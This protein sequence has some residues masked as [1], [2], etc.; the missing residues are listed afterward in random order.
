MKKLLAML[1]ALTML[2]GMT[3]TFASAEEVVTLKWVTVGSGMPTNYDAW[4]A[5]I[6][7]YLA[8]KIGVNVDVEVIGWGDW[9][10]R[11]NMIISTN[12]P[13]D[14]IFGNSGTYNNDV[15]MGAYYEI[16]EEMLAEYA[17]G[18]MELIPSAYWDACRVGGLIY[19]VPTYKDSSMTNYFVWDK[20]LLDANGLDA[21]EGHTLEAIEPI[22][23]ELKD[24]TSNTVY[25]L[26]SNGATY[27]LS[28]YDQMS[29]GLPAIGV[30]IDDTEYKVVATLEQEDI[31]TSLSLL[32]KWYND[33]IINADAATHAESNKYNVCSVAQGWPSAAITTWGPNMGV[34]AVAYQF[35][36]TIA[37][38]ETV[39]G[40]LNSISV[41]CPYPEKALQLLDIINTDTYVRDLFY[42]GVE[43]ENW[44]YTEDGR[45][46]KINAEWTMAG[47]TQATFFN[48]SLTDDMDFN[49]WDEVRELNDNATA[50]VLLGFFFDTTPIQD[51]LASCI[52]IFNR[53]KGEVLTGTTD[54]AVSVPQ[55]MEEMRAAGF[56]DIVAE[57]Q[58]QV[59]A[60][61]AAK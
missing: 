22:L 45:V 57:A 26:N 13:Y 5:Q 46:H 43:G 39:Q 25:P 6:N 17:P 44:E 56:D 49:Q 42:Y 15:Q 32:H 35:G 54:P 52:E 20:E 34:E 37:S 30:R 50:S 18:L 27:L 3:G 33:G 16:T 24:K 8:E 28:V 60:F 29:T 59:D 9:D 61:V 11:R 31:M 4:L 51:Q 23:Y 12:E 1:L 14:I 21:S 47:Y 19:A 36:D 58:A 41:N 7:P 55:M 10:N 48:V 2:L 53:Y 38:N 40:S